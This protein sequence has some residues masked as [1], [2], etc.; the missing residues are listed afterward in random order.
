M[1]LLGTSG[2]RTDTDSAGKS[3]S[4]ERG[5]NAL[6]IFVFQLHLLTITNMFN[7]ASIYL[8]LS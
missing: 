6:L 4:I 2:L 5:T 1:F 3:E 7:I 8:T